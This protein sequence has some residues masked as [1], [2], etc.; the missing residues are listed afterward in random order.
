MDH[1][2]VQTEMG[3]TCTQFIHLEDYQNRKEEACRNVGKCLMCKAFEDMHQMNIAYSDEHT[4]G[5]TQW[6]HTMRKNQI[7]REA[8]TEK[9]F[10]MVCTQLSTVAMRKE[11]GDVSQY[12]AV[13]MSKAETEEMVRTNQ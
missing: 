2:M 9:R 11:R 7:W 12:E 8:T 10:F 1:I 13:R 4:M 5:M 3:E 6:I